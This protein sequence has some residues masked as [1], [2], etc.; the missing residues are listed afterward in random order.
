MKMYADRQS[1]TVF[2]V[3]WKSGGRMVEF[4]VILRSKESKSGSEKGIFG[5]KTGEKSTGVSFSYETT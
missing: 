5:K 2:F 4:C 1:M 3:F